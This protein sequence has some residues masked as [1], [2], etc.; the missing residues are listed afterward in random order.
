M[1]PP[2]ITSAQ[3]AEDFATAVQ[4]VTGYRHMWMPKQTRV[5][6][7]G[8]RHDFNKRMDHDWNKVWT[9]EEKAQIISEHVSLM[10]KR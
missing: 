9:D 1:N 4:K 6:W 5:L 8:F 2:E 10:L 3:S 7:A